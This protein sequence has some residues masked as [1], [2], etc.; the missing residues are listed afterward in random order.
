MV[1]R[2]HCFLIKETLVWARMCVGVYMCDW[3]RQE[4]RQRPMAGKWEWR[5][6]AIL[7]AKEPV[8][9]STDPVRSWS[10]WTY[11]LSATEL[12]TY[13]IAVSKYLTRSNWG[14]E[15]FILM[16]GLRMDIVYHGKEG[17]VTRHK[18]I[19]HGSLEEQ[20]QWGEYIH[21]YIYECMKSTN[22]KIL[23]SLRACSCWVPKAECF[24]RVTLLSLM[25]RLDN[26][27]PVVAWFTRLAALA[28]TIFLWKLGDSW[29]AIISSSLM[30]MWKH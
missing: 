23:T 15:E 17:M 8:C 4:D 10:V 20:N 12:V 14:T 25:E 18:C 29:R 19:S 13:L 5:Q 21:T 11:I 24:G 30:G 2:S 26:P 28:V 9:P 27:N 1:P 16:Y 6:K 22:I 7:E 3:E